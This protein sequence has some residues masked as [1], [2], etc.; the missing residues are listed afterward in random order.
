MNYE[1]LASSFPPDCRIPYLENNPYIY[2]IPADNSYQSPPPNYSEFSTPQGKIQN[3][4][5]KIPIHHQSSPNPHSK[6]SHYERTHAESNYLP[7]SSVPQSLVY[8]SP[9]SHPKYEGTPQSH[10]MS[11]TQT[12]PVSR[13]YL[14]AVHNNPRGLIERDYPEHSSVLH[15]YPDYSSPPSNLKFQGSS[16]KRESTNTETKSIYRNDPSAIHDC[17]TKPVSP[18][19]SGQVHRELQE[20]YELA[21]SRYQS[22]YKESEGVYQNI[23]SRQNT[24]E[25]KGENLYGRDLL[26][27]QEVIR[28]EINRE[29]RE[30]M[31]KKEEVQHFCTS[32]MNANT[33]KNVYSQISKSRERGISS[34]KGRRSEKG[35]R[36]SEKKL[37]KNI[38]EDKA[39][40]SASQRRSESKITNLRNK[41]TSKKNTTYLRPTFSHEV[42]SMGNKP[43]TF[44]D[45]PMGTQSSKFDNLK[46]SYN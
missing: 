40:R 36:S 17:S 18:Y 33:E 23:G 13:N 9:P 45:H 21:E 32:E 41:V 2:S 15:Q 38:S 7:H 8:S 27:R 3:P 44:I 6:Q 22:N 19:K 34:G 37:R 25:F 29:N 20:K 43:Y 4:T 11:N 31:R 10:D 5:Q 35:E 42:R 1:T 24:E 26:K 28:E 14:S 30:Y 16:N 39:E 46:L 12:K